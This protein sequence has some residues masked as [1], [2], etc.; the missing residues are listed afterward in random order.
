MEIN[1]DDFENIMEAYWYVLCHAGKG[2]P[3]LL[4]LEYKV[5]FNYFKE[6]QKKYKVY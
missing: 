6:L 2:N 1:E 4:E 3:Q 5:Y